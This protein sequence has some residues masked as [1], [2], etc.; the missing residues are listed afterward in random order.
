MSIRK[1]VDGR[2]ERLNAEIE[3]H[4]A[5][6]ELLKDNRKYWQTLLKDVEKLAPEKVNL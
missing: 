2:L 6:I 4:K 3:R 5:A 1:A